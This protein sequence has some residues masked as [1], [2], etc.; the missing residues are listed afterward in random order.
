MEERSL[1]Q[2]LHI[3]IPLLF[4]VLVIS[5]IGLVVL[6][7]AGGQDMQLVLRQGIRVLLA[8]LLMFIVAQISPPQLE[9]WSMWVYM[10]GIGL[11]LLVLYTGY[12]GKGAQRWL[13]LGLF[14][15]QPS[16]IMK[17]AVPMA[18]AWYLANDD[19]PPGPGRVIA[20]FIII[21]LPVVLIAKQPWH[22]STGGNG[23]ILGAVYCRVEL[24]LYCFIGHSYWCL[25]A[26]VMA[27][28][29]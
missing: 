6:Y 26:R 4:G 9:R 24:A 17:L 27:F 16:E 22:R 8:V 25:R 18:V 15:F 10:G 2:R 23:R 20:V 5:G 3:D 7:S 28:H 12:I 1:A 14:S 13:D 29:A 21:L 19:L 11:L